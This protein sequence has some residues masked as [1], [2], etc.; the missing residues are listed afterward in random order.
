MVKAKLE[1]ELRSKL[2]AYK[3][4]DSIHLPFIINNE[5]YCI[6]EY[7]TAHHIEIWLKSKGQQLT[8]QN[9]FLY[10]DKFILFLI[11]HDT[12]AN[13][14]WYIS[15][16]TVTPSLL[17]VVARGYYRFSLRNKVKLDFN[18]NSQNHI[19][20]RISVLEM[21]KGLLKLMLFYLTSLQQVSG[22]KIMAMKN[23]KV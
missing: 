21:M 2:T 13:I 16:K 14:L 1:P 7:F 8:K 5:H 20:T 19:Y 10:F 15:Q 4:L 17:Q 22:K 23:L 11:I 9:M 3:M 18:M 12:P 6:L